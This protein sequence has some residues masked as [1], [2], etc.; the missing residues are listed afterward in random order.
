MDKKNAFTLVELLVVIAI[1]GVLIALL[2]PAVQQAREAARRMSCTNNIKQLVLALHNYESSFLVF[3]TGRVGCDG[4]CDPKSGPSTSGFVLMLPQIEQG[5]LYDQFAPYG[6]GSAFPGNL[7]STVLSQRPDA[8]VCPSSIMPPSVTLSGKEWATSSYAFCSGHYGPDQGIGAK[9]K[10]D[11]SG[12]FIYRDSRKISDATD[13]LSNLFVIGEV[14]D[15]DKPTSS[16]RW[17]IGSRLLDSL[18]STRNPVNTLPGMGEVHKP[19]DHDLNAAFASRHPGGANFGFGDGSVKFIPE[20]INLTVY[21]N[22][23]RR[24]SG[25]VKSY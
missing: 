9:V 3:P 14:V 2:L 21:R 22:L 6:P 19:Y 13:G 4:A 23:G 11:N 25:K 15:G 12:L 10:W 20:T 24:D 7:P 1:I 18:R 17:A 8:F 16:N 5:A